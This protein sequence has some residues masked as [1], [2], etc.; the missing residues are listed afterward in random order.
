ML[1]TD[2]STD[3]AANH[4]AVTNL[5]SQEWERVAEQTDMLQGEIEIR[6]KT[7]KQLDK[8]FEMRWGCWVELE[9]MR[10]KNTEEIRE[11]ALSDWQILL[12]DEKRKCGGTFSTYLPQLVDE[13]TVSVKK[14]FYASTAYKKSEMKC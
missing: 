9:K 12:R 11:Q 14:A 10:K 1:T 2:L 13:A 8:D 3:E 7:K 4:D 6:K 5:Y